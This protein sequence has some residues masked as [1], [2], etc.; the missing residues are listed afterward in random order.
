MKLIVI[1]HGETDLNKEDRLQGC[2]GPD[3]ELNES[4]KQVIRQLRDTLLITPQI[5]YAS[6]LLR[7]Q[8]T[9]HI[10]NERFHLPIVAAPLLRE[11]DFGTLSVTIPPAI[12]FTPALTYQLW[13]QS[14]NAKGQSEPGPVTEWV[15]V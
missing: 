8:E 9:A 14:R 6:P 5:I 2:K 13:L 11:R 1:R 10:L 12:T 7:T 4:G 3:L 15:A